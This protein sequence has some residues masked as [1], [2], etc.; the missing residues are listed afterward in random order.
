MQVQVSS[1]CAVF[2]VGREG[3]GNSQAVRFGPNARS[4][5]LTESYH[6]MARE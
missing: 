1:W 6:E 2:A 4:G 5:Y 3:K